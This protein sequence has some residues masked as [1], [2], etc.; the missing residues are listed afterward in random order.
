MR[1]SVHDGESVAQADSQNWW[2]PPHPGSRRPSEQSQLAHKQL[3]VES[4]KMHGDKGKPGL[5]RLHLNL[6]TFSQ[7]IRSFYQCRE[8]TAAPFCLQV[9]STASPYCLWWRTVTPM[10]IRR[11][12]KTLINKDGGAKE[13]LIFKWLKVPN[14]FPSVQVGRGQSRGLHGHFSGQIE[15]LCQQFA[16]DLLKNHAKKWL[17][18]SYWTAKEAALNVAGGYMQANSH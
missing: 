7:D 5:N 13:W 8:A 14:M 4:K 6:S 12:T 2:L 3:M 16:Q 17:A 1:S 18:C 10:A 11:K 9:S 15:H